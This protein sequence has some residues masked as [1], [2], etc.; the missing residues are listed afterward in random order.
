MNAASIGVFSARGNLA[1][2]TGECVANRTTGKKGQR[3]RAVQMYA[4]WIVHSGASTSKVLIDQVETP[5]TDIRRR[6]LYRPPDRNLIRS[7]DACRAHASTI[8]RA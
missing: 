4:E 5:G 3:A 8:A 1:R 2:V 7:R 6:E